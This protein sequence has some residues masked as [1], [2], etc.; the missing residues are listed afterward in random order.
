MSIIMSNLYMP[1]NIVQNMHTVIVGGGII[2]LCSAYH[3]GKRGIDVTVVEKGSIGSG[4]TERSLG[5]IRRQ[6]STEVNVELSQISYEVWDQFEEKF[7]VDIAFRQEGYLFLAR[8]EETAANFEE[9]V[10]R[11]QKHGVPSEILD[12]DEAA[13][14]CPGLRTEH[15]TKATFCPTDGWADPHLALQA[16]AEAA[17]EAG[18]EIRTKT[19]VTDILRDGD[20][21]EGVRT[22]DEEI[23]A[24]YVVNAAG[25]WAGELAELANEPMPI[26]PRR[27]QVSIVDPETS[28]PSSIPLMIDLDT[29]SY[30]RPEREGAA[31]V[32]GHFGPE[33]PDVDPGGYSKKP[34]MEWTITAIEHVSDYATYFGPNSE[35]K[36]GW[37]GLYAITPDHHPIIEETTSGLITAAGF[38]GHGFQHAPATGRIVTDLVER[39]C[40]DR[41]DISPLTSDRFEE[42]SLIEEKNVA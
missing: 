4:N 21:V 37:A 40:T 30:F 3:L 16:Y 35:I 41:V 13:E 12:P 14:H 29:G 7:G 28:V 9:D 31:V 10:A 34:D 17:R 23:E 33:D 11:Q 22:E 32:G 1:A 5:G 19:T 20:V 26:A 36:R 38:S 15:F 18:A 39:G 25:A 27:R 6:F 24:D 2:G 42:G 8:D